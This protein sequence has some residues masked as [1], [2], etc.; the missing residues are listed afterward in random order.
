VCIPD[1]ALELCPKYKVNAWKL[2]QNSSENAEAQKD[3]RCYPSRELNAATPEIL[4]ELAGCP[5]S[6]Y[7]EKGRKDW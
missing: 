5:R 6:S 2:H 4:Q 7:L 3:G 1:G